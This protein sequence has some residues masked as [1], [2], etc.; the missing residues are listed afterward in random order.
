MEVSS[1]TVSRARRR[2]EALSPT[3]AVINEVEAA[4]LD[5]LRRVGVER[6]AH[7]QR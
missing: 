6:D 5:E 7:E 2:S 3:P 1:S 4:T